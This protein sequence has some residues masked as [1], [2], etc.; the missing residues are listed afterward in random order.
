[1]RLIQT[2]L[3]HQNYV[4][5]MLL[6][7]I[8][9]LFSL[10]PAPPLNDGHDAAKAMVDWSEHAIMQVKLDLK[11]SPNVLGTISSFVTFLETMKIE[12]INKNVSHF[13][14]LQQ[15]KNNELRA[16]Y[17]FGVYNIQEQAWS[18]QEI[19]EHLKLIKAKN[20]GIEYQL[21]A[22]RALESWPEYYRFTRE[23]LEVY[24]AFPE[25]LELKEPLPPTFHQIEKLPINTLNDLVV[26]VD[27]ALKHHWK[28]ELKALTQILTEIAKAYE[29]NNAHRQAAQTLELIDLD[30]RSDSIKNY[31]AELKAKA[32]QNSNNLPAV[33]ALY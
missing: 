25:K 11:S 13:G 23:V 28:P 18:K 24:D 12:S 29:S 8:Y 19:Y 31:I 22:L 17:W 4:F 9:Q 33:K 15:L 27:I 10:D 7:L 21:N 16:L 20:A 14:D 2:E 26:I 6:S 32:N 3:K 5:L 30:K 1:M